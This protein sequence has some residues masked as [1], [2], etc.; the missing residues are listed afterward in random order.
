MTF[1][2]G[3]G[4]GGLKQNVTMTLFFQNSLEM[5]PYRYDNS[6]PALQLCLV[7]LEKKRS[8][9]CKCAIGAVYVQGTRRQT[10]Y[11]IAFVPL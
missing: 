10:Y 6:W 5:P 2:G 1:G 3:G 11:F 7:A 8:N 9:T 4:G